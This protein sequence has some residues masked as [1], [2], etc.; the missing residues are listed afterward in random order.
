MF[1][2]RE[3]ELQELTGKLTDRKFEAI[4]L[5]GKRRVGKTEL[6]R[7]AAENFDGIFLYYE[8]KKSL[9]S[10]NLDG[11]NE[12]L[13]NTFGHNR[14]FQNFREALQF[15]LEQSRQRPILFA[16]DELQ[17]LTAENNCA[18]SDLL[19]LID[20]YREKAA[21]KLILSGSDT[22][23]IKSLTE[24]NCETNSRF[25]GIIE[26]KPFDYFD[27]A[28]FYPKYRYEDKVLMYAVFGGTAFNNS[29]IDPSLSPME[30]IK[31]LLLLPDSILQLEAEH[32]ISSATNTIPMLNSLLD[33]I[34]NGKAKYSEITN[35]LTAKKNG[36]V[37]VDYLLKKLVEL[38][39]IEKKAPINDS[40]NRKK[41]SY[42]FADNLMHFY[43]RYIFRYKSMNSMMDTEDFYT[44]Y[45]K[46]DFEIRYL[47]SIFETISI[48]YLIRAGRK[49]L[50]TPAINEIGTYSLDDRKN[51]MS[52]EFPVVTRDQDGYI[53]YLCNY[54][55]NPVGLADL[56]DAETLLQDC[57]LNFYHY[58]FISRS[59][60]LPKI[61]K[62]KYKLISLPELYS[63]ELNDVRPEEE[64]DCFQD[65]YILNSFLN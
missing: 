5:Y 11:L 44:R 40:G 58:G 60:F 41:V 36:S 29:L 55:Y 51:K 56:R 46:E 13:K 49:G 43:Y 28:K 30:N 2:G 62:E 6:I 50:I 22:G 65:Q 53:L 17:F 38:G 52:Q 42:C 3:T 20:E 39:I 35:K 34:V 23:I 16:L 1:V 21:C 25:T 27:A 8:C 24:S 61:P 33:V 37:N 14:S 54:S 15:V 18:V 32:T 7:R 10:D 57:G 19:D 59:G 48:E 45:V 9:P 31:K 63:D 47:P 4:L 26:L 12:L 64:Y